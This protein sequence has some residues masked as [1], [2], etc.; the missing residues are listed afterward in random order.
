MQTS[1][2]KKRRLRGPA[3]P[4]G[5]TLVEILIVVLIIGIL[6][7]I[8][9]PNFISA[10]ETSRAK[11]CIGSLKQIDSAKQQAIMDNHL[12][13]ASAAIF[14]VDGTTTSTS[15]PDGNYQLVSMANSINYI[16]RQPVCPS[17]GQYTPGGVLVSPICSITGAAGSGYAAGEKWY[18]GY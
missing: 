10:R 18:H 2:P 1:T 13:G 16:R 8:A 4:G 5:F 17:G 9:I 7:A 3:A 11:S 15:G 14:F 6:L 12:N